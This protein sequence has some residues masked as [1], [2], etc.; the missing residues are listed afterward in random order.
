MPLLVPAQ[1]MVP[2]AYG[3]NVSVRISSVTLRAWADGSDLGR[4][5]VR[6]RY[7]ILLGATLGLLAVTRYQTCARCH[8]LR[9]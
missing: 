1:S 7:Q 8:T 5:A 4:G 6:Q 3:H 2:I 9:R